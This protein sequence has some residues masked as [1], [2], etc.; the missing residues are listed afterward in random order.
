MPELT[1]EEI[2]AQEHKTAEEFRVKAEGLRKA[3]FDA[4]ADEYEACAKIAEQQAQR[5]AK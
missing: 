3:G 1:P 2:A 5:N 4:A